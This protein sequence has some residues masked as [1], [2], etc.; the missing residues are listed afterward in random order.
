MLRA[1]LVDED[2]TTGVRDLDDSVLGDDPVVIDVE[3]S[4][5][6]FKDTM[7]RDPNSR[8]A[9]RYPL[10]PG[11]DVSGAVAQSPPGGP[12]VGGRALAHG[13]EIGA[14]HHGG[15][16]ERARMPARWTVE[17]PQGTDSRTA[18]LLGTAGFTAFVSV[19]R[20]EEVG[21]TP[22]RG[23]VLVT[24][25]T[26]GVGSLAVLLLAR[27][28]YE[29]VASTG[30]AD[31]RSYLTSLGATQVIGRDEIGD[32]TGPLGSGRWAG[33]VDCVGGATLAAVLRSLNY[34]GAVAA[35]GLTGGS[36]L[37]TTVYPFILRGVALL[38]V[39]TARTPIEERRRLWPS[40]LGAIPAEPLEAIVDREVDLAGLDKALDDV[41]GARVTGRVLVNPQA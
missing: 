40:L 23:P 28:G 25:A 36:S 30:K 39:D 37:T 11:V 26:G 35:S 41:A 20:L 8:V 18:A 38:G 1:F 2:G 33:A 4:S 14:S 12:S 6:N 9:G 32:G 3:W 27:R 34:G 17:L 10:I 13:Y 21:L 15:F 5:I 29:V 7:V 24:G 31:R 19:L 16:A 22:E